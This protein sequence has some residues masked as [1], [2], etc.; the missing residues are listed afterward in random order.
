MAR[1]AAM[2][3]TFLTRDEAIAYLAR[4][5]GPNGTPRM[6]ENHGDRI[7]AQRRVELP[8][9]PMPLAEFFAKYP[10]GRAYPNPFKRG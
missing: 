1:T 3:F 10:P 8:P 4:F 7:M 9:A 5:E 2:Q 6:A